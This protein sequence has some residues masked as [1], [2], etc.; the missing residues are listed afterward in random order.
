MKTILLDENLPV[1]LRHSL[2]EFEVVTV[3]FQGWSGKQNGE[4]IRLIDGK[5][6]VFLTGDKNLRYQQRIDIRNIAIV[7]VPFTRLESLN[8]YLEEIKAAI[9]RA[10]IGEYIQIRASS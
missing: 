8:P 4:L 10:T 1:A 5:F 7:E 3:Q 6:D 2:A 9:R